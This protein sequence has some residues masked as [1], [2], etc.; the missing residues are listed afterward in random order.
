MT[1]TNAS[2]YR[3]MYSLTDQVDKRYPIANLNNYSVASNGFEMVN[4]SHFRINTPSATIKSIILVSPDN[5]IMFAYN[6][7]IRGRMAF[8]FYI[9]VAEK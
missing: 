8:D 7:D 9:K 3:W 1:R 2:G 5:E 4:S 6:N